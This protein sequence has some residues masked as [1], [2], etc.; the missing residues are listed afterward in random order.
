MDDVLLK[1][2]R[3]NKGTN[4]QEFW[5]NYPEITVIN[6]LD[7]KEASLD[8]YRKLRDRYSIYREDLTFNIYKVTRDGITKV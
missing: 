6:C 7:D 3:E 4:L 5:N 1:T 2:G 8:H